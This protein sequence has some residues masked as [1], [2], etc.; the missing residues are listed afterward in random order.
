MAS[1]RLQTPCTPAAVPVTSLC[2]ADC[3]ASV[4]RLLWTG[5]ADGRVLSW[6]LP[7]LTE[8]QRGRSPAGNDQVFVGSYGIF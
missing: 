4:D 8:E 7:L 2:V 6:Q 5:L 3:R 1:L